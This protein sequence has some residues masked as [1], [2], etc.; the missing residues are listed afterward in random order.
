MISINLNLIQEIDYLWKP[1]YPYLSQQIFELYGRQDGNI[2]EIGPFCGVIFT[3]QQK[4]IGGSFLIATFPPGMGN[5][6]REE[7]KKRRLEDKIKIIETDPSLTGVEENRIDLTIF[8]GAFFFPSL[9]EVNF[10]GIY[11][12]LRTDGIAFIG[13]GFGKFTPNS[14]RE[15]IRKRSRDLNLQIGKIEVNEDQLRRE[16][17]KSN[18]KGKMAVISEGGLWVLMK[19]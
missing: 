16:I 7:A 5:F 12:V 4:N 9:F 6:F 13:G 1:V 19:K 8:R 3:L 15:D 14:V 17:V 2:L 11:R 18:V 10:S